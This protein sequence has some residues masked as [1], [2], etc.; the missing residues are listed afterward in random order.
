M[1]D[2]FKAEKKFSPKECDRD[3]GCQA[4]AGDEVGQ[5]VGDFGAGEVGNG[6][7]KDRWQGEKKG[8]PDDHT[9]S[10]GP[11]GQVKQAGK[12]KRKGDDVDDDWNDDRRGRTDEVVH[13][14]VI[15][16]DER[17]GQVEKI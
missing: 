17:A 16:G 11:L 13:E 15:G 1:L 5:P 6:V 8:R 2:F 3:Q 14:I 4:D 7:E 10:A 12:K 9:K